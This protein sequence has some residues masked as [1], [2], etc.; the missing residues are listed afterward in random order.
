MDIARIP[1]LTIDA[2]EALFAVIV[3][4]TVSVSVVILANPRREDANLVVG[5]LRVSYTFPLLAEPSLA[6][7][8]GSTFS[9]GVASSHALTTGVQGC[10]AVL[11]LG[12][13]QVMCAAS[14]CLATAINAVESIVTEIVAAWYLQR[15]VAELFLTIIKRNR[16]FLWTNSPPKTRANS[17]I[18]SVDILKDCSPKLA[19]LC[20]FKLK[21]RNH[22]PIKR[23][24][25]TIV[26][27]QRLYSNARTNQI[28]GLIFPKKHADCLIY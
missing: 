25:Y 24:A 26:F 12:T 27:Y 7:I 22:F 10:I 15:R 23:I 13:M 11:V 3:M 16:V 18:V 1:T 21:I 20:S 6:H 5:T 8:T 17:L 2:N 19:V 14:L 28:R 9:V 4:S